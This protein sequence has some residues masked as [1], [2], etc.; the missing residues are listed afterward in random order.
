MTYPHTAESAPTTALYTKTIG[1][2][3]GLGP[4]AGAHF[5]RQLVEATKAASDQG[6]PRVVL[7]SDPAVPS[8]LAH[9]QGHGPSPLPALTAVAHALVDLGAQVIAVPSVTTHAYYEE[10][11]A[12]VPVPVVNALDSVADELRAAGARRVALAVTTPARASG[13]L[14]RRLAASDIACV[15]PGEAGQRAIQDVVDGVKAGG[16]LPPLAGKLAGVFDGAWARGADTRLVGC[17]DLSPAAAHLQQQVPDIAGIY[18]RAL[19]AAAAA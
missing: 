18:A 3:G 12:A 10:I 9:L 13:L 2:V 14:E 15:F 6:H 16:E 5:Y 7:V 8:R 11:A 4:L 1:I 19:L 17:T